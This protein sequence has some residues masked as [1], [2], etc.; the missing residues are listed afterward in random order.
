LW[1]GPPP[2]VG[3]FLNSA[4]PSWMFVFFS[5]DHSR[6]PLRMKAVFL[7]KVRCYL[8]VFF[9]L[10]IFLS[11]SGTTPPPN[12]CYSC[13]FCPG[14]PGAC[15]LIFPPFWLSNLPLQN[16]PLTQN[17]DAAI[18]SLLLRFR[19]LQEIGQFKGILVFPDLRWNHKPPHG[20]AGLFPPPSLCFL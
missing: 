7:P 17:P 18:S 11:P 19:L 8:L 15:S 6:P 4:L 13:R 20:F 3:Y 9:P 1:R 2:C 16:L 5:L 12:S 14:F 10:E